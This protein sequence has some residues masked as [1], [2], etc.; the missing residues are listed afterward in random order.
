MKAHV[1]SASRLKEA[2]AL[3]CTIPGIGA[4]SAAQVL[5]EVPG[6]AQFKSARAVAAYAGLVPSERQSGTSVRG[7]ARLSKLGNARLRK[8]LYMPALSARRWNPLVRAL[9]ERLQQRG[10]RPKQVVV[11]CM[12]KL[13]HL[14]YGVLK[15]GRPF[16]PCYAPGS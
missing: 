5:S 15:T 16:D 6:L 3:L 12:R 7:R 13:L 10:K 1:Q 4:L 11:A 9:G 2:V 14:C 8:A